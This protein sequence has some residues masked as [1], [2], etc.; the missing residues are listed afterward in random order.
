MKSKIIRCALLLLCCWGCEDLIEKNLTK[1]HVR[2]I[3]P[4]DNTKTLP[5]KVTFLW[6]P[7]E[8]ATAY[9]L[10]IV[11]PDFEQAT[12][13]IC[14]TVIGTTKYTI[15]LN[16]GNYQWRVL[17]RNS[18]YTGISLPYHLNVVLPEQELEPAP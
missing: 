9:H 3:A 12:Q 15:G 17:P 18:A 6:Q 8:G 11:S 7:T 16:P 5:G 1:Q 4:V 2:V 10:T 13:V 14:D